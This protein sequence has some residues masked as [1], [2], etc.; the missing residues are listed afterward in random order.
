[1]KGL[2][3]SPL[4]DTPSWGDIMDSES[5]EFTPLF[6]QQLLVEGDEIEGDEEEDEE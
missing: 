3:L 4:R 1:Q 2:N 6:N 5:T